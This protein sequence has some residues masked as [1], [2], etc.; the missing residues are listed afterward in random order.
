DV[1]ALIASGA[2][3][4][5]LDMYGF[6]PLI[7]SAI[8]NRLDIADLLLKNGADVK[9]K[10][11]VGG[12]ALQWAVENYNLSMCY[13][14]LKQGADPNA[15]TRFAQPILVQ[16]LLRRQHDL[17]EMLYKAGAD[18]K[19][20]QDYI[21]AKLL[22]HRFELTGRVDIV[23]HRNTFIEMDF[24]G[25]ILEF[26]VSV[27]QDSLVY[28]RN[29]FSSRNLQSQFSALQVIID[30]FEIAAEM[31][32]YQQ[33]LINIDNYQGKLNFFAEQSNLL[34]PVGCEGHAISFIKSGG[35]FAKCDRG[36]N[37]LTHPSVTIYKIGNTYAF[38]AIFLKHLLYTVQ[39]KEFLSE[40][41]MHA[42]NLQPIIDLPMPSQI[43]G[44][45]SWANVEAAIPTFFLMQW[46]NQNPVHV[47]GN[48]QSYQQAAMKIYHQWLN[49]D[50]DWALH[51][52]IE[53]FYD[54]DPARKASKAAIL[55][56]VLFQTCRYT[57][58][59]DL[60]RSNKILSVL[61]APK[62]AYVLESYLAV[63]GNTPVGKNLAELI[64]LYGR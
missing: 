63:Y 51:Q 53:S 18:L 20:A 32:T 50:K 52:C 11:M 48:M 16:P 46:I 61:A 17:K 2:D 64:D 36:E 55:A 22:G 49:W 8:A 60:D 43:M 59:Q 24:A 14:F 57:T 37:S 58:S 7:E 31:L 28:F 41:I 6:T 12:T 35:L 30:A 39:T 9:Q 45:C 62:Y 29:N 3:V 13:M 33:H 4:N 54:A 26:T 10:D 19:F 44:N 15:Y 38:N 23:D 40:G 5:M 21:N 47:L 56:A 25:F 42:L 1:E 34:L 27:I